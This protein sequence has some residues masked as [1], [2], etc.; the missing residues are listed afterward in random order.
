[1]TTALIHPDRGTHFVYDKGDLERCLAL[2]WKIRP[3]NWKELKQAEEQARKVSAIQAEK[4]RLEAEL[5]A[6]EPQ[7]IVLAESAP[8]EAKPKRKYVRK[9]A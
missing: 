4:A 5:A 8:A 2:G 7:G 3:D 1:M 6:L 9:G